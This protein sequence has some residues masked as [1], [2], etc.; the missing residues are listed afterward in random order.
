MEIDSVVAI[1]H[2][3]C[4]LNSLIYEFA[5]LRGSPTIWLGKGGKS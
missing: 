3:A 4:N 2:D 1:I 5:L